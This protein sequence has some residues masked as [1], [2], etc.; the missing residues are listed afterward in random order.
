MKR[1]QKSPGCANNRGRET[2][3]PDTVVIERDTAQNRKPAINVG[4]RLYG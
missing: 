2:S 4:R 3:P 1:R